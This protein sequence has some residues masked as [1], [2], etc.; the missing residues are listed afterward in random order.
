[1]RQIS[2]ESI[3][4]RSDVPWEEARETLQKLIKRMQVELMVRLE[5]T[6]KRSICKGP[7]HDFGQS[8]VPYLEVGRCHSL[9]CRKMNRLPNWRRR[10]PVLQWQSPEPGHCVSSWGLLMPDWPCYS[11]GYS[12]VRCWACFGPDIPTSTCMIMKYATPLLMRPSLIC[13]HKTAAWQD[14]TSLRLLLL[15]SSRTMLQTF[16]KCGG[17]IL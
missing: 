9:L 3:E 5:S 7:A 4:V 16:T 10:M 17:C 15:K 11:D 8:R 6:A 12:H 2:K 13:L 1:M 14:R